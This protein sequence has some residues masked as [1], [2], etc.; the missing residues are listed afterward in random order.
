MFS[1][2]MQHISSDLNTNEIKS[3]FSL[4]CY[5]HYVNVTAISFSLQHNKADWS[6]MYGS[7]KIIFSFRPVIYF[8]GLDII[9]AFKN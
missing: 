1:S 7:L 3:I 8:G 9:L 6:A 5:I 2:F 4:P